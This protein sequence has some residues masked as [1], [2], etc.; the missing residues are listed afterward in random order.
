MQSTTRRNFSEQMD[1]E[2]QHIFHINK[3]CARTMAHTEIPSRENIF[4]TKWSGMDFGM[5]WVLSNALG[6]SI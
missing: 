4:T 6:C 1:L 2:S 3:S 5:L